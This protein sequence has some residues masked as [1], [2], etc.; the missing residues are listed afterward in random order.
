MRDEIITELLGSPAIKNYCCIGKDRA[1]D[2]FQ[3][4]WIKILKIP[5][6]KLVDIYQKGYL[7]F[8]IYKIIQNL[9]RVWFAK[10][11]AS[12]NQV[13]INGVHNIEAADDIFGGIELKKVRELLSEMN[14]YE[15][16]LFEIYMEEGSFRKVEKKTKINYQSVHD[17]VMLVRKKLAHGIN[18]P[19][20]K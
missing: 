19:L 1:D 12:L 17:T 4:A 6:N 10:N 8:Y 16:K 5:E 2:L 9:Q 14:W 11:K 13:D 3:D 7:L 15:Q 18:R 20:K